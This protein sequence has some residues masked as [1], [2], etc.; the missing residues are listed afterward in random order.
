MIPACGESLIF[1]PVMTVIVI[2][3]NKKEIVIAIGIVFFVIMITITY[4]SWYG[5]GIAR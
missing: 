1:A 4:T 2:N 3:A 5:L